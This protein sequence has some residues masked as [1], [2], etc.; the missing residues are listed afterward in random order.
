MLAMLKNYFAFFLVLPF[1]GGAGLYL[2]L[3]MRGLQF[4]KIPMAFRLLTRKSKGQES[5][6][7]FGAVAAVLGGNLGTGNISGIAMALSMGGPGSLFWMWVMALLGAIIKYSGTFLGVRYREL[8]SRGGY[9][10]GPMYYLEKALKMPLLAKVFCIFTMIS[11]ITVGNFVQINSVALP[12]TEF[13]IHPFILGAFMA[14][15]V[16]Y[17]I[18]GGLS[19]FAKASMIIVPLKAVG[20]IATSVFILISFH[21][22]ILPALKLIIT[23]AFDFKSM[24]TGVATYSLLTAVR[25]GFARG[26]FATDTGVGL[27]PILHAPVTYTTPGVDIAIAQGVISMLSPIVVMIVCSLTGVVLIVT[28]AW[29]TPGLQSTNMC[30]EAYRIGFDSYLAGHIVTVTL[31]FFAMTTITTWSYCADRA[32]EYLFGEKAI[33]VFQW[34]F[35]FLIPIGAMA[36]VNLVWAVAD[37]SV[38]LMMVINMI[39]ILGLSKLVIHETNAFFF[40]TKARKGLMPHLNDREE[41][42]KSSL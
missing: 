3:R 16:G 25:D 5:L 11:A 17:V 1:L 14:L 4:L 2:T 33:K 38:N 32:V 36:H 13:G 6:S 9:V 31:F 20:Y 19:R 8:S 34:I 18:F 42:S 22:A 40:K 12:L 27:A 15:I 21:D 23:S 24:F 37:I 7:S 28:G 10:G 26:L 35:V 30:V 29:Q 41:V 39:G